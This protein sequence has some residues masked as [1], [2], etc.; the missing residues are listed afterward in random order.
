[1]VF[2]ASLED[3]DESFTR[4]DLKNLKEWSVKP[5]SKGGFIKDE[6]QLLSTVQEWSRRGAVDVKRVLLTI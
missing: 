5:E 1:V 3:H 2:G 4:N 6:Y